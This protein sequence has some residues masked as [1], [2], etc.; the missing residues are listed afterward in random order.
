MRERG[1]GGGSDR[2]ESTAGFDIVGAGVWARLR[3]EACGKAEFGAN[4]SAQALLTAKT[5]SRNKF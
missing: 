5:T 1:T 2:W 3:S 4:G